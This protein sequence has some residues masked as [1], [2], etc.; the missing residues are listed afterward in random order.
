M[1]GRLQA[2]IDSDPRRV[3]PAHEGH[4]TPLR[5]AVTERRDG[6]A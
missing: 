1:A 4:L 5:A 3:R 6:T 2:A